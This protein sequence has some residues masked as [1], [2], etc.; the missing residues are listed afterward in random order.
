[1]DYKRMWY[2]MKESL[3]SDLNTQDE[4]RKAL[5]MDMLIEMN[6][7]EIKDREHCEEEMKLDLA[8]LCKKKVVK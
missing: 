2:K 3:M 1:M 8:E 5:V 4:R 7:I 6:S